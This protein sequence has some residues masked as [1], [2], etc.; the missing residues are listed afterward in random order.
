MA[1][2]DVTR[3]G[4]IVTVTLNRPQRKNAMT[5]E[6]WSVLADLFR[7]I[8]RSTDDRV[9]VLTGAEGNFC[10]GADLNPGTVPEGPPRHQV[11]QMRDV[12]E[13]ILAWH[14]L[15]QP[16]IAKV[17]GVCVGAGMNLALG[18]DLVVAADDARFSEIF[19][20]RG[21][22]IDGGGAWVL[23]RLIGLHKAKELAL[24]ADILSAKEVADLGLLNR[25]V[26][27]GEL[28]SFVDDWAQRLAAGP[29]IALSLTKQL[30]NDG[31]QQTMAQVLDAEGMAQSVNF[32]TSDTVEAITAFVEK[33]DPQFK[34]Y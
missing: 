17:A 33:R 18:S 21:L 8:R 25:V 4:G 10:S 5:R 9:V 12:G 16:T 28:D 19:A 6:M 1:D 20:R 24:F 32:S 27:A 11:I 30:L 22:S 26:P 14:Q 3:D 34:G 2:V 15:P 13:A 7:E 29:P 23:P 31:L